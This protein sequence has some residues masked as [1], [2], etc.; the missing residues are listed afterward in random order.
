M[1]HTNLRK[2][3]NTELTSLFLQQSV[4]D[5]EADFVRSL[6]DPSYPHFDLIVLTASNEHQAEGF[7]RQLARRKFPAGTEVAVIPDRGGERVGSG[8]ATLA[9]IKFVKEKY[10]SFAGRRVAVLHSG[11]DGKRTPNYSAIGKVF[12][13]VPR[14]LPDGRPSTL[15]DEYMIVLS[16]LAG[17]LR[18]GM[19][20]FSGDVLLLFNPLQ[21][22]FSG[23]GAAAI[24]FKES[25]TTAVNHGVFLSG[26]HGD[27][28]RFLH[29]QS[30]ETLRASGAVNAHGNVSID[31]GALVFAPDLLEALS[32]LVA[33]AAGA[34]AYINSRVRLSLYGDFLYPMASD[35]TLESFYLEAP[36]WELNDELHAARTVLWNVLRP[37]RLKIQTFSPAKFIHFGTTGEV[38]SLMNGGWRE[39]APQ[40]WRHQIN[41]VAD[42]TVAAY[43]SVVS[44]GARIGEGTYLEYAYIHHTAKIGK[45]CLLSYVDIHDETV[46]DGVV[47]HCLKQADSRF[48]CR[49]YGT[50]D[51]PKKDRLFGRP[52]SELGIRADTL[53]EAVIY[54]ICET[55][56]QAV[57][58]ALNLY[59]IATTD[60]GDLNAWDNAEKASLGSGFNN[61][62]PQALMAWQQRMA[63]LVRMFELE[64]AIE[65]NERVADVAARFA[66]G[67]LSPIQQEWLAHRIAGLDL[68][69]PQKFGRAIRLLRFVAAACDNEEY[70]KRWFHLIAEVIQNNTLQTLQYDESFSIG[71]ERACVRL[72]LRV[73]WGGGWTDTP[74]YCIENGGTVLNCAVS[75]NRTLPV[76]VSI[77]RI[78][79]AKIVF[80]SRDMDVHGEF[81]EIAPLQRFGDPSDAFALQKACLI[82]CGLIPKTG[83][84]LRSILARIGGGFIMRSEVVNVPKGSGLGTS[85]ILSAACAK[86]FFHFF[87]KNCSDDAL[88]DYVLA[89][90][91][92]M[93]T[94]GGWQD[95]VGG[96]TPGI[97]LITSEPGVRQHVHVRHVTI[98][99]QTKTELQ[100]RFCLIYTGQRRLARNLLRDVISRY[101]G[102]EPDSVVAHAQIKTLAEE[103]KTALCEGNVDR[104]ASLLNEH[105]ALSSVINP[106]TVNTLIE[107]IFLTIDDMVDGKF[108]CG[109]GGGGFLQV[110]L[111]KGVSKD[112]VRQRLKSVFQDFPVDVWDC[113][114]LL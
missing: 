55:V 91:Q 32:L 41:S 1:I 110:I 14:M 84:D 88:Y 18:E 8:G 113:E 17:R 66:V 65:G 15:F 23:H 22:D 24:S 94:G 62:D 10:G 67:A 51:N 63:D 52:L 107:Y 105:L 7:R 54:P 33:D 61:A 34:D 35:S 102:N 36:E 70:Q 38:M 3:D 20:L 106:E 111:K 78:A 48:V 44:S 75:L 64:R 103:M 95:Q 90:E 11:G 77:E 72:P 86:A 114:L 25:V 82:A 39:F 47:L 42:E 60:G 50:D 100:E 80:D 43:N 108:I 89:M 2:P 26:N 40:G 6:S 69:D 53:W 73:N 109:A 99:E 59:K 98:P 101:V 21:L 71:R 46:P 27:V 37:F 12:S 31:T 57:A 79:D 85:S 19:L 104:F 30:E 5:A 49:I 9:V 56:Q 93:T 68:S 83:G 28:A 92:L 4:R 45:H 96:L 97:K 87:N 112:E 58:A 16:G 74:P 29:K 76:C 13:P 81:E